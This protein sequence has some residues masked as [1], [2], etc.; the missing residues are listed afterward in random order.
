MN[1][2][3]DKYG[4]KAARIARGL[5]RVPEPSNLFII[6][7]SPPPPEAE[8]Q[9]PARP[10]TVHN[11]TESPPPPQRSKKSPFTIDPSNSLK[12][13]N[14]TPSLQNTKPLPEITPTLLA[15]GTFTV[16]LILDCREV[17][18]KSDREYIQDELAGL[19]AKPLLRSLELG[20]AMWVAEVHDPAVLKGY[21]EDGNEVVLDWIVERK[22]LDDL[23]GSIKDGRFREQKV[24]RKWI[25]WMPTERKKERKKE[26]KETVTDQRAKKIVPT[27]KVWDEECHLHHRGLQSGPGHDFEICRGD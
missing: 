12:I 14:P 10:N 20:D 4:V 6:S 24:R 3:N 9:N 23:V 19:G 25:D 11:P 21:G 7:S 27:R 1:D 16:K 13:N 2:R 22:R 8:P 18:S 15:A 17:R 26:R 5:E